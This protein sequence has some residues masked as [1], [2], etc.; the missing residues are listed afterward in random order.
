MKKISILLALVFLVTA[1]SS[2]KDLTTKNKNNENQAPTFDLMDVDGNTHSLSDYAGKKVY[3]KFWA[4]WCS[5]CLSGLEEINT[6]AV[7]EKDFVVLTIVSPGYNN[8]KKS[9]DFIK[10]FKGVE[11]VSS[12]PVLLDEDGSIAKQYQVRGYPTSAFIN[13]DGELIKTQAGHLSNEQIRTQLN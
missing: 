2:E 7:E 6:L 12:I 8:E 10:W 5:I 9:D 13:A 11:D 4:S 1:C 3:I